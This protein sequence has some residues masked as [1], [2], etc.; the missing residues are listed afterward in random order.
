MGV[1]PIYEFNFWSSMMGF[2]W[3]TGLIFIHLMGTITH[4]HPPP[5]WVE[6]HAI[7]MTR[8]AC[9]YCYSNEET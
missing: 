7:Y 5:S 6:Q 2:F 9:K 1:H 8:A 3:V 4:H